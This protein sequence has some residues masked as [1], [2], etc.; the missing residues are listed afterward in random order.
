MKSHPFDSEKAGRS[1]RT[2]DSTPP[3]CS[4]AFLPFFTLSI[5][6]LTQKPPHNSRNKR[7]IPIKYA[8]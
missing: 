4:S 7:H 5:V 3:P 2:C 1:T 8:A 6:K